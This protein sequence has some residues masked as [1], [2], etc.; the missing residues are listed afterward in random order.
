MSRILSFVCLFFILSFLSFV[1]APG[2]A[3]EIYTVDASP[4]SGFH[5]PYM[6]LIPDSI[7]SPEDGTPLLVAPN[8]TGRTSDSFAVHLEAANKYIHMIQ[9]VANQLH[10]PILMPVFP[11][12]GSEW[13]S[14][15]HA[16]DRETLTASSERLIRID[17]QLVAMIK[18]AQASLGE[19]L[20]PINPKSVF[21]GFSASGMFVN[22]FVFLHPDAVL[23]GI[24]GSPGGWPLAPVSHYQK[25]KLRFPI[26]IADLDSLVGEPLNME[27]VRTL[28]LYFFLGDKD[29]NDSVVYEDSYDI[30]DRNVIMELFGASLTKRWTIAEAMYRQAGYTKTEFHLFSDIGHTV[31]PEMQQG[32]MAFILSTMNN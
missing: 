29:E 6:L 26:G 11:R 23:A 12:P 19:R 22:R 16:L 20:G 27:R 2:K 15:I 25:K 28:P 30:S 1:S 5:W 21:L 4:D 9:P 3:A 32:I 18:H 7:T 17:K 24:I 31:A 8:N 14:Y 13:R 10:I